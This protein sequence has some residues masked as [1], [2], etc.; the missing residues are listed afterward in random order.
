MTYVTPAFDAV[1]AQMHALAGTSELHVSSI[2]TAEHMQVGTTVPTRSVWKICVRQMGD[3][4]RA[5]KVA[6]RH[7]S[8]DLRGNPSSMPSAGSTLL[9]ELRIRRP[10][11]TQRAHC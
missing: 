6:R 5:V 9:Y 8:G 3:V 7:S 10:E 2:A 1:V 11:H 4:R